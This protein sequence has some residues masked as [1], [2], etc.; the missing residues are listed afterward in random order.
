MKDSKALCDSSK[1]GLRE[2]Y[3]MPCL[4]MGVEGINKFPCRSCAEIGNPR[5]ATFEVSLMT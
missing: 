5:A 4:E 2:L 3:L 1:V